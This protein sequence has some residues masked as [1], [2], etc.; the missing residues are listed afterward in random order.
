MVS[1]ECANCEN[2]TLAAEINTVNPAKPQ[3]I[4]KFECDICDNK[5]FDHKILTVLYVIPET[6]SN[7]IYITN[8]DL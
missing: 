2:I 3:D 6:K 4:Y 5:M 8:K 7:I 1:Y